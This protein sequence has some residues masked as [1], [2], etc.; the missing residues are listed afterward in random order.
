MKSASGSGLQAQGPPRHDEGGQTVSPLRGQH[1]DARQ[2]EHI[3]DVGEAEFVLEGKADDV[4]IGHR[5]QALEG[6]ERDMVFPHLLLHVHPGGKDP[7]APD[8]GPLV[9]QA[10]KDLHPQV[11]HPHVIG[12]GEA[13]GKAKVHP[14]SVFD[15]AAQLSADVLGGLL[16]LEQHLFNGIS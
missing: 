13:K 6:I 11:G 4:K 14:V 15:D 2:I 10:V 16:H 3:Q 8:V 12:V 9:E 5:V 1:G 7:L